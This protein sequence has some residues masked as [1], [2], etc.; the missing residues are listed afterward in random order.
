M[1]ALLRRVEVDGAG[2]L[3]RKRLLAPFVPDPDRLLD[4]GHAGTGQAD[5]NLGRRGL[6][7][8]DNLVPGPRHTVERYAMADDQRF[9]RIV[10]LACHDLR[11]PLATVYGFART[12]ERGGNLDERSLRFM[13]MISEASEQMTVAARRA[14]RRGADRGR[15]L[16]AGSRRGRHAS[17]SRRR[18]TSGSSTTGSGETIETEPAAVA[19]GL[20]ALAIAAIRFGP[21]EQVTWTVDGRSLALAPVVEAAAPVVLGEEIR[22]LGSLV[23]RIVI[24]QLGGTLALDGETL[25]VQLSSARSGRRRR[26][27][28]GGGPSGTAR[29]RQPRSRGRS[30][31]GRGSTPSGPRRA[32]TR[33]AGASSTSSGRRSGPRR[34]RTGPCGGPASDAA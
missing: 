4:A 28:A 16:R 20:E 14:R 13:T 6:Q 22:D 33:P 10:S 9:S 3:G 5:P 15:P 2:D 34:R 30:C 29:S 23:A 1:D 26:G 18:R 8:A 32:P 12:L 7:I 21:V 11:T 31:S 19:R 17:R 27:A 25:R 24:E